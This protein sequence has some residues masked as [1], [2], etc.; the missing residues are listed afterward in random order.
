MDDPSQHGQRF[1]NLHEFIW[2][3]AEGAGAEIAVAN[4]FGDYGFT[5]KPPDSTEAD[6]GNN[7]E[8]KW[9]KHAQGHLI[10]QNKQYAREDMVAIMVTGF[11]PVYLVMGWMPLHMIMQP[12]Y[13]HPNQG[14]YWVPKSSLFEMQYLKRSNYG[15]I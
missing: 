5:P 10:V 6:V 13:R 7:I 3:K 2:Q 9:T 8:V 12:K 11:S 14:N 4:Y 1:T 15:D